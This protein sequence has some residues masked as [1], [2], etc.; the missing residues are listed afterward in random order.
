MG[1]ANIW[2]VLVNDGEPGGIAVAALVVCC[3]PEYAFESETEALGG[4]AGRGIEG[5]AFPFIAAVAEV[6]DVLHFEVHR[7]GRQGRALELRREAN[8]AD[9]NDAIGWIDPQV[10]AE[11]DGFLGCEVYVRPELRIVTETGAS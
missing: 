3:L 9:F 11:P 5:I 4:S 1:R 10:G 6:E 7:L 2:P 8:V